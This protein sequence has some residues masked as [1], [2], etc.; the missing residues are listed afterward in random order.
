MQV[1]LMNIM[2][3]LSEKK[4]KPDTDDSVPDTEVQLLARLHGQLSRKLVGEAFVR[5]T[6]QYNSK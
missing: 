3:L 4:S 5:P 1:R 6:R 2:T